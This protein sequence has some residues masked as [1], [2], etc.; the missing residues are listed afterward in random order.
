VASKTVVPAKPG[1]RHI[2]E[3]YRTRNPNP[4]I[5]EDADPM[6]VVH[7]WGLSPLTA[8]IVKYAIRAGRKPGEAMEK[9]LTKIIECATRALEYSK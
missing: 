5:A 8:F 7:A 9:D 1:V 6:D 4:R 3:Y 2:P